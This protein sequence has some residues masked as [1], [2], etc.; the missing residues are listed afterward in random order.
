MRHCIYVIGIH[1]SMSF[2]LATAWT[3]DV[4]RLICRGECSLHPAKLMIDHIFYD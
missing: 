3:M 1:F 4:K 2:I